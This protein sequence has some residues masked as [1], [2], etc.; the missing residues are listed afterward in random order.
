MPI[1]IPF[2]TSVGLDTQAVMTIQ[3]ILSISI[4]VLEIPSGY[5]GDILGRKN[6]LI[7]GALFT[8][9]GFAVYSL[10]YGFYGF[11]MAAILLGAGSSFISGSDSALL[12]DTL[13]ELNKQRNFVKLEGRISAIGNFSESIAG[14]LGGLLAVYSLRY[15][16]YIQTLVA[17]MGI[18]AAISLI[19]PP[20][21]E[22]MM[23][24]KTW[25]NIV[26]VLRYSML[27]Q[28]VLRWFIGFSAFM[29]AATLTMAWFA[30]VYFEFAEVPLLYYGILWTALNLSVAVASWFAHRVE[31]M[32]QPIS[33]AYIMLALIIAGYVGTASLGPTLGLIS[34]FVLYIGRGFATPIL[35]NFVNFHT[36]SKMRATVLSIRSFII[37]LFFATLAPVLGY[38]TDTYT[39]EQAMGLAGV[40]FLVGG[41]LSVFVLKGLGAFE[42][43]W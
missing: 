38:I 4:V 14:V 37:R 30:Q 2:Y 9:V 10:S 34:I 7:I 31:D 26:E 35:K 27:E 3:A 19:E 40:I 33:L 13:I 1:I 39:L 8:V 11:L 17:V 28:P 42:R 5:F 32:M 25:Q 15:P 36:P 24:K 23:A 41:G 12:Y 29:G 21:R 18:F 22:V 6:S 20:R 16:F 43:R